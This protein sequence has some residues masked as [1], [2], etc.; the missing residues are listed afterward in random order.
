MG[1]TLLWGVLLNSVLLPVGLV[2][3]IAL[4]APLPAFIET[5][6]MRVVAFAFDF[7]LGRGP[8]G[9]SSCM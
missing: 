5:R 2:F 7:R 6:M 1:S 9:L 3:L 4:I 8:T